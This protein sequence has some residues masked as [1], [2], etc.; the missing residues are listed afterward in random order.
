MP[1]SKSIPLRWQKGW[2]AFLSRRYAPSLFILVFTLICNLPLVFLQFLTPDG[3]LYLDMGRNIFEG[4]GAI[5]T[6]NLHF[7]WTGY[8]YPSLPYLHPVYPIIAGFIWTLTHSIEA[9]LVFNV[10]LLTVCALLLYQVYKIVATREIAFL[11]ALIYALL[12]DSRLVAGMPLTDYLHFTIILVVLLILFKNRGYKNTLIAG[13][14]IGFAFLVRVANLYAAIAIGL[15]LLLSTEGR[16]LFRLKR[17]LLYGVGILLIILPYEL[18]CYLHYHIWYP[19][20]T[21]ATKAYTFALE[22]PSSHFVYGNPT[23]VF[24]PEFTT[25]EHIKFL[26]RNTTLHLI[27]FTSYLPF[28]IITALCIYFFRRLRRR[29]GQ[30]E[31]LTLVLLLLFSVVGYSVSIYWW[32][33]IETWRYSIIPVA[34]GLPLAAM[35]LHRLFAYFRQGYRPWGR[36]VFAFVL[37]LSLGLNLYALAL[38]DIFIPK[39]VTIMKAE[40]ESALT[41]V[42]ENSVPG[43]LVATNSTYF[44]FLFDRPVITLPHGKILTEENLKDFL[45]IHQPM[46][47]VI[48][49]LERILFNNEYISFDPKYHQFI[50]DEGYSFAGADNIYRFYKRLE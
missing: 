37:L 39:S 22:E 15:A 2:Q 35:G 36:M 11:G 25:W 5:L 27:Q 50:L 40:R 14:L 42:A 18:F 48:S 34:C 26:A 31:I 33:M 19:Q 28:T 1:T 12:R 3:C 23:L 21:S 20:Y 43:D 7:A 10:A 9:V 32:K 30:F 46:L 4:K 8:S 16:F 41:F 49:N 29:F 17:S 38:Y 47:I 44:M 45:R 13:L 24:T 6:L